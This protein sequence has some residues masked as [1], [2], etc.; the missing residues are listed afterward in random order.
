MDA[1]VVGVAARRIDPA[2]VEWIPYTCKLSGNRELV[3]L[4]G[5]ELAARIMAA[6]PAVENIAGT[7]I[8]AGLYSAELCE[9]D[10]ATVS[11]APENEVVSELRKFAALG[12]VARRRLHRLTSDSIRRSIRAAVDASR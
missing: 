4:I 1:A 8:L 9:C 5:D 3:L 6:L 12:M 2:G 10:V 7:K 11:G